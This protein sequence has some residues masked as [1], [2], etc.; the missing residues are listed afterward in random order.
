MCVVHRRL[1]AQDKGLTRLT[2][3]FTLIFVRPVNFV[4]KKAIENGMCI[5]LQAAICMVEHV[6]VRLLHLEGLG[7]YIELF[8]PAIHTD[9]AS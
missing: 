7:Q 1:V 4:I 9:P 8:R 6:Y 3:A 2:I 5:P